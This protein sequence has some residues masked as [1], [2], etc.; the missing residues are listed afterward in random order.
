M[1]QERSWWIPKTT[2]VTLNWIMSVPINWNSF[3]IPASWYDW[4]GTRFRQW[5]RTLQF[6]LLTYLLTYLLTPWSRVVLEK[7]TGLAANQEIPRILWNPK[8]HYRTHKRPPP[9]PILSHRGERPEHLPGHFTFHTLCL[10]NKQPRH[11][12][13]YR[14]E[15]R[16]RST[17]WPPYSWGNSWRH[18]LNV[19]QVGITDSLDA[20]QR[21]WIL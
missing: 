4:V 8:V 5:G 3:K 6:F 21:R 17:H 19:R 12:G 20:L 1:S 7:P 11:S 16:R 9:V 15:G 14:R 18:K 2:N 13:I 10:L